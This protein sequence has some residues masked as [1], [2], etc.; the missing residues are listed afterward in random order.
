MASKLRGSTRGKRKGGSG[1]SRRGGKASAKR[2]ASARRANKRQAANRARDQQISDRNR[3]R[4]RSGGNN[5]A[6][7]RTGGESTGREK[8]IMASQKANKIKGLEQSIGSLDRRINKALESGNTAL[9]KDLRSRQNK[10]T[11]NLG[12]Q[13]AIKGG[14]VQRDSSGRVVRT[15]SGNPVLNTKGKDIF[16]L[17]KDMDFIDPTRRIQNKEGDSY[18]EM[19]PIQGKIQ[20]GLPTANILKKFFDKEDKDIPYTEE[21]M[22]GERYG[23]DETFGA[24][25]DDF[26]GGRSLADED[27]SLEDIIKRYT[28][29][30]EVEEKEEID[31]QIKEKPDAPKTKDGPDIKVKPTPDVPDEKVIEQIEKEKLMK[32]VLPYQPD[33]LSN[34]KILG[35]TDSNTLNMEDVVPSGAF[36]ENLKEFEANDVKPQYFPTL[37]DLVDLGGNVVDGAAYVTGADA[38]ADGLTWGTDKILNKTTGWEPWSQ[39][40]GEEWQNKM[41]EDTTKALA[42]I[43]DAQNL[44]IDQKAQLTDFVNN[45]GVNLTPQYINGVQTTDPWNFQSEPVVFDEYVQ[46]RLNNLR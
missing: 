6:D 34:P 33:W 35:V 30:K 16:D 31:V 25:E 43:E 1:G 19:Y 12:Y 14:G 27:A 3:D 13:R 10:F 15:S 18:D 5:K 41:N 29:P 42:A 32:E 4:A 23:L 2:Q 17:T 20:K 37:A 9:A 36:Q 45:G 39:Y 22:P 38:I 46:E 28:P 26:Y 7:I 11:T 21:L 40:T 8:G 24:Y 44:D